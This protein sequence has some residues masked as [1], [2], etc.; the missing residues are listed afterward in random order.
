[1]ARATKKQKVLTAEEKLA[2]AL[3]PEAEQPYPV[4]GNWCWVTVKSINQYDTETI[5]PAQ[6]SDET[7]ELYSVPSSSEN[8]PEIVKGA[9]IGSTKQ[10]VEKGDVL[11]CKINP[12]I[13]RVWKVFQHT[14]N[15]LLA[16][17][18]WIIIRNHGI[19]TEY[20]MYC[21]QSPYFR[22]Y[23]LSNV[24]GVGGSLMRA[25][26]KYVKN[27]PVPLPPLVEQQ[28][29]VVLVESLFA[30]LDAA[31]EKL[32]TVLDSFA[33]RR[34][35]ILHQAFT[36]KLTAGWR[37]EHGMTLS[38]WT[39]KRLEDCFD[40][41]GGIQKQ[42][43]R[44]PDKNPVPYITV[45]NVY[46]DRIDLTDLRFF[47]VFDGEIE[48]YQLH[49]G[50]ILVVEG[51]GSGNEIGRC[52]MWRDELPVCIHQNHIIRVRKKD[53]S[54]LPEYVLYYLNSSMGNQIMKERARTTAGLYSLSTGKIKTIPFPY[55]P[56][57]EQKEIVR[58]LQG[59]FDADQQ[60][61]AT[62][63]AVFADIAT[64]KKSILARAFRGEL[65]T[66]NP[67]DESA[68]ELLRRVL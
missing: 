17:S 31:K 62:A 50:D 64:M 68:A 52:A 8:Y 13:N 27:Y 67:A 34:A 60:A 11:L 32:Q 18:E 4:P 22:K 12:R 1:M 7:Y 46:R 45:A 10:K 44:K 56:I 24:S 49:Y 57:N 20:L 66:G 51:N 42:P 37:K 65:G 35:A 15:C 25:Q 16:S 14:D 29:I 58:I 5:D 36:G 2:A 54:V 55:A 38:N 48:K 3:V 6:S 43:S 47:E 33:E 39:A 30:D 26:P 9:E 41:V 61:K 40:I 28:R 21:F 63:E 59:L 53:D 23:M 19:N